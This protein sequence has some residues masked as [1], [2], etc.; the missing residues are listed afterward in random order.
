L[1][2]EDFSMKEGIHRLAGKVAVVTGGASGIGEATCRVFDRE[3]ASVVVLDIDREGA[4][5]VAG[6][7]KQGLAVFADV[8]DATR[9]DAGFAAAIDRFGRVDVVVH[10]AAV[11][12]PAAKV[13]IATNVA[14]GEP[15]GTVLWLT[16]EQWH[17]QIRVNLDGTFFVNRAA[18]RLMVPQKSGSIVNIATIGAIDPPAGYVH[19]LAAKGGMVAFSRSVAKDVWSQ[20]VRVNC[21]APGT[22]DTPM[23]SRNPHYV[24]P[25]KSVGRFGTAEEVAAA[26][27]FLA[28][29]EASYVTGEMVVVSGGLC[30]T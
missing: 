19:Y 16:D 12:D 23:L 20:G 10:S 5:R 22:I 28:S 7:L 13:R 26:V 25:P 4:Q 30:G 29:D 8:G 21:V 11:D 14:N 9:V 24:K 27:L 3:G 18:L 1:N 15:P 6:E 17:H 2:H